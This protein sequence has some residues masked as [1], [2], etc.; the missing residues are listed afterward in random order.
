MIVTKT[1]VRVSF[2]G[3]GTDLE[4]FYRRESGLVISTAIKQHVYLCVHRGYEHRYILKYTTTELADSLDDIRHP[5]F[6][7][8][9]R[10]TGAL[11]PLEIASFADIPSKGSGLG[12]SSSFAVGLVKALLTYEGKECS[13]ATCAEMAC[14]IEISNLQEPI[15]KQD[16]YA[17][18]FGGLNCLRFQADGSVSVE[19]LCLQPDVQS[20][21]QSRLVMVYTGTTRS[22]SSVLSEQ[23][24]ATQEDVRVFDCLR[25]MKEL[26][27]VFREQILA[28]NL[29]AL[30]P[31]LHQGW[32]LKRD[33]T[34][35]TTSDEIDAIYEAG[36]Q[37]GATGG[38]L[39]GAGGGGY[40]LFYCPPER[41][42][43]LLSA[44]SKLHVVNPELDNQGTRVICHG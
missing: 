3:G 39:L 8:C 26:A 24:R 16:Q 35:K 23:R 32:Q 31:L 21:F 1:P 41:K 13:P 38:K 2:M 4:A 28:G 22:A 9:I 29:D 19:N 6:R 20:E 43:N 18:A 25:S 10:A 34:S 27:E 5:L 40:V 37:A 44:L 7:E 15:G 11:P 42:S 17:A 36:M 30:G 14:N 33:L 12:S